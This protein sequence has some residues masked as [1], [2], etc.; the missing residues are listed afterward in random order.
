M[1]PL[2]HKAL[3]R[4]LSIVSD[5]SS[6]ER[7][8]PVLLNSEESTLKFVDRTLSSKVSRRLQ[9]IIM[10]KHSIQINTPWWNKEEGSWL[11]DS[12]S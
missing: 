6:E 7:F 3:H 9:C 10:E 1:I 8:V 11:E 4:I 12:L 2:V 5:E